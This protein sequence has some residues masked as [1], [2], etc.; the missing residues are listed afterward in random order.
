MKYLLFTI[1]LLFLGANISA[2][3]DWKYQVTKF[4]DDFGSP[5]S[6]DPNHYNWNQQSDLRQGI[7]INLKTNPLEPATIYVEA[8]NSKIRFHHSERYDSQSNKLRHVSVSVNNGTFQTLYN[9]NAFNYK[10]FVFWTTSSVFSTVGNHSLTVKF[11]RSIAGITYT[12]YRYYEIKVVPKSEE[13]HLDNHLNSIRVWKSDYANAKPMLLSVGLDAHN[14]LPEQFQRHNITSLFDCLLEN[15]DTPHDIYVLYYYYNAQDLRRNAAVFNSAVKY[16]SNQKYGGKKIVVGGRSMGGIISRYALA[17]AEEEEDPLPVTTWFTLDSPHQGANVSAPVLNFFKSID[18]ITGA[19]LRKNN[20]NPAAMIML[21]HNPYDQFGL[22]HTYFYNELNDWNEDGFPHLT[23][24]VA[25]AFGNKTPNPAFGTWVS[26]N[27]L[28]QPVIP[29]GMTAEDRKAGSR[30]PKR[31]IKIFDPYISINQVQDPT[32]M[33]IKSALAIDDN[34][35]NGSNDLE[36]SRFDMHVV[37]EN[38][39]EHD[40]FPK[41]I[42][43]ELAKEIVA[44]QNMFF[45][46]VDIEGKGEYRAYDE[47]HAG[48][49]VRS[50]R[51]NGPVTIDAEDITFKAGEMVL[52][53]SDVWIKSGA[54]F[55]AKI[56]NTMVPDCSPYES[57]YEDPIPNALARADEEELVASLESSKENLLRVY[58]NPLVVD[59]TLDYVL[60][61]SGFVQIDL[62]NGQGQ[63]I[64]NI[65]TTT[66][67]DKGEHSIQLDLSELASGMYFIQLTTDKQQVREK[68]IK[69]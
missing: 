17:K 37:P 69:L 30:L 20:D 43:S 60:A 57:I 35:T 46:D 42:A 3:V 53:E 8:N 67:G 12:R 51:F 36:N 50:D 23:H 2:Q 28:G 61:Q 32:F 27:L 13:L 33:D 14:I 64:K 66:N 56:Q 41:E 59:A 65:I 25:A 1:G 40:K 7:R 55:L 19:F 31:K 29:F 4:V 9:G 52:L 24:N 10:Y 26:L 63:L 47:I 44:P 48:T 21:K 15:P 62:I 11:K 18:F 38:N 68:I 5:T 58:P 22:A 54:K 16:V 34:D 6:L 39:Y 49:D 45:Q